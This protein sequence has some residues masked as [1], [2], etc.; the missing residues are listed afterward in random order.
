MKTEIH[1]I[2]A[3]IFILIVLGTHSLLHG[4]WRGRQTKPVK[5]D[6]IIK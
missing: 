5:N 3:V 6:A 2:A 4:I 1:S